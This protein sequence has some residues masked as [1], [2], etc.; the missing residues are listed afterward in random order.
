MITI[1]KRKYASVAYMAEKWDC[2]EQTIYKLNARKRIKGVK[3]VGNRLWILR[4][5]KKPKAL[6]T[7]PRGPWKYK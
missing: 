6:K 7:G 1:D 5:A 4:T 2:S 3:K